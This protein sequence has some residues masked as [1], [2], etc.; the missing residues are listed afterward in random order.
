M[1]IYTLF[2]PIVY[3]CDKIL[4]VHLFILKLIFNKYTFRLLDWVNEGSKT[5]LFVILLIICTP[6]FTLV[7]LEKYTEYY[8]VS[9]NIQLGFA[10]FVVSALILC[11]V[12]HW[13]SPTEDQIKNCN[14][15]WKTLINTMNMFST[16][17]VYS[18]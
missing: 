17:L 4:S 7:Y 9:E 5:G 16:F 6:L 11:L 8:W 1:W 3:V 15:K 13:L 14:K 2:K 12:K 10:I 18:F